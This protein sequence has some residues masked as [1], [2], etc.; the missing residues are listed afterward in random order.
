MRES[1]RERDCDRKRKK[2]KKSGKEAEE[3]A[4]AAS[5]RHESDSKS[6]GQVQEVVLLNRPSNFTPSRFFGAQTLVLQ[7]HSPPVA[8][9]HHIINNTV[10]NV[11]VTSDII[12][13]PLDTYNFSIS[14]LQRDFQLDMEK[15]DVIVF[16][17]IQKTGGST[18]GRHLIRNLVVDR[19]CECVRRR[20]RCNCLTHSNKNWLFSRY[21]TG[22]ICG[23]HADWT[24][25]TECVEKA[26]DKVEGSKRKRK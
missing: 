8:L 19:P 18:F 1:E 12:H 5:E 2:K 25:L 26:L 13:L 14:D 16:L 20:K 4:T 23:L 3:N 10:S 17:H 24:E 21:S 22:W 9:L 15:E 11:D 6:T 7:Q